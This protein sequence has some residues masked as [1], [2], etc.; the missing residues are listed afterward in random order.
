MANKTSWSAKPA[1]LL[2]AFMSAACSTPTAGPSP[3]AAGL[4]S[5][6]SAIPE[7]IIDCP[8]TPNCVSSVAVDTDKQTLPFSMAGLDVSE[9]QAQLVSAIEKDG[10][11][12]RNQQQGYIWATYKSAVFGFVDDVE[13]LF[14]ETGNQFDVRSASRLGISDFGVNRERVERLRA[15]VNSEG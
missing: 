13:W 8:S 2:S 15:L 9:F 5:S 7:R 6:S 4:E 1:V 10:G 11:S 14:D 3:T 12:V